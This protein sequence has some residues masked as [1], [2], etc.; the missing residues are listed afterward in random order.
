MSAESITGHEFWKMKSRI[1]D[2]GRARTRS[3][4]LRAM[5]AG[6][7]RE[8][9]LGFWVGQGSKGEQSCAVSGVG[10]GTALGVSLVAAVGAVYCGSVTELGGRL[11]ATGRGATTFSFIIH[12]CFWR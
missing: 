3:R 6:F 9:G 12:A 2:G 8:A 1:L 5:A 7:E 4:I 11:V 10:F